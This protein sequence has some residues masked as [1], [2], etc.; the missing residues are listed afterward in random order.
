MADFQIALERLHFSCGFID[1]EGGMRT[2]PT[3]RAFQKSRGLPVTGAVDAATW[4]ALGHGGPSFTTYT[5]T[6]ADVDAVQ[7]PLPTWLEKSRADHLGYHALWDLLGE[8]FH[9]KRAYLRALN[10]GEP[11]VGTVLRVPNLEPAPPPMQAAR[12]EVSLGGRTIEALDETGRVIAHFPCSIA[13]DKEKRPSGQL[14]VKVIV[15]HPNYTFD[16]KLFPEAVANEGLHTRLIIPPGPR[17]PVGSVWIGLSLPGYGMHGTP[18][19]ENVARTM[20]H[21]CFR[22]ANWNAEALAGLVRV[23]TPVDVV[24]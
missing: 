18:E 22:L 20:S 6:Q 2:A 4:Q 14:T 12:V 15:H 3:L 21:G 7:P 8:K 16:P 19:P 11:S 9:S 10:P 17:N 24:E 1:G 5:V 23:G 13:K